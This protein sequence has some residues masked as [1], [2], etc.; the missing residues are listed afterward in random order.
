MKPT[1]LALASLSVAAV[2]VACLSCASSAPPLEPGVVE[3]PAELQL[4]RVDAE[5]TK[6]ETVRRAVR[7]ACDGEDPA[8]DAATCEPLNVALETAEAAVRVAYRTIA[9]GDDA[10]TEIAALKAA[11]VS[12][13]DEWARRS[14]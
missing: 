12:L 4:A 10:S 13:S 1:R 2:V 9:R 3:S 7:L 5:A 11:V 6:Y 14:S 8:L